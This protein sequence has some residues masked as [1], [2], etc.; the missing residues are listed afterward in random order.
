[1]SNKNTNACLSKAF[2]D[3]PIFVL[4]ARDSSA[5]K[6]ICEWIKE[7]LTTQPKSKLIEALESA[8]KMA[9]TGHVFVERK[10]ELKQH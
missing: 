9:Q 4:L 2:E 1:M 5:P 10:N 3:E 8:I 7:N 6:V